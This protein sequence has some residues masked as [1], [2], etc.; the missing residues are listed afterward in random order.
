MTPSTYE[1][2]CECGAVIRTTTTT[3]TCKCGRLY[4]FQWPG[5]YKPRPTKNGELPTL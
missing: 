2:R 1:T 5:D 4:E 3:G